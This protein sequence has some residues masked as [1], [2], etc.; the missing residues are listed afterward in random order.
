M[1]DYL[2][3]SRAPGDTVAEA[4]SRAL[5]DEA[6]R[7][8][9]VVSQM[10]PHAWLAV[11]GPAPPRKL[12]V[13]GWT[14]IGDV[15]DRRSAYLPASRATDPWDYERKM[16]ARFWGRYVGVLFGANDQISALLRDPSGALDCVCWQQDGL[17]VVA[18]SAE[19][20]LLSRLRPGWR[21]NI[22]RV[23][24]ALHDVVA[25]AGPLMI[26]GPT[27]LQPGT[28]QPLPLTRAPTALWTPSEIARRS[29]GP[30]QP[31]PAEAMAL[32][33]TA[34][35][36]AV[37][38]LSSLEGPIA[39]EVSGGLDSSII[40]STLM[41][42]SRSK[43]ALWLNTYGSTP[44]SDER[45]HVA[46]LGPALGITPTSVPHVTAPITHEWL[47]AVSGGFRPGLNALDHTQDLAWSREI[48][49]AGAM[50]V[51]TGK[52]GDSILVQAATMDVFADVWKARGWR[53]LVWR[54]FPELA[55]ANEVSLWSMI[56]H[57]RRCRRAGHPSLGREH[58][59]LS[60]LAEEVEIHPWLS[61]LGRFGPA[62][63]FQIA[64]VADSVSHHGASA[65]TRSIDVR[66]PLCTQPVVEACLSLPT[67]LLTIGGRD[68]GL[69]RLAFRDHLPAEIL[70]RRSKGEMTRIY[71]RMVVDNLAVLRPWLIE[72]RLAAL[73]L[74]DRKAAEAELT[75]EALIWRGHYAIILNVA[76]MEGWVRLWERRLGP[77]G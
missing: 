54:D 11:R 12:D 41:R 30:V 60:K 8:G 64:G 47:E 22:G 49:T 25:D 31:S 73:G 75:P 9:L 63:T 23:A 56:G 76:A 19:D 1:G 52:G 4:M 6:R 46:V 59:L 37:V 53:A 21:I 13:G 35:E 28:I 71:G 24:R 18:S 69:A 55:A 68:R 2:L 17:T 67:S 29:L 77:A 48:G 36:D 20:W 66:H 7:H 61:D 43:V 62:K 74:V 39:A 45:R 16:I 33:R 51:M 3:V 65:L 57:A 14:L 34:I 32:L 70:D 26:D 72:G 40:A 50:A 38:G 27:A 42:V 10:N 58:P 15:F 44:E 5:S